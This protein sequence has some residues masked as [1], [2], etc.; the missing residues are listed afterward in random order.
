[1]T[2]DPDAIRE[3][4]SW[5]EIADK[6]LEFIEWLCEKYNIDFMEELSAF[7]DDSV[8]CHCGKPVDPRYAPCCSLKHWHERF[9]LTPARRD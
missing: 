6:R 4:S 5:Q 1:M 2:L 8:D 9:E 7:V 3:V